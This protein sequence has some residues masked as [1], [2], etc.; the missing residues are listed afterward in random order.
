MC[1]PLHFTEEKPRF[2][3][4]SLLVESPGVRKWWRWQL[5]DPA[6]TDHRLC[7]MVHVCVAMVRGQLKTGNSK[8]GLR[9]HSKCSWAL[10]LSLA[11]LRFP[12][13]LTSQFSFA[14]ASSGFQE[15]SLAR[16]HCLPVQTSCAAGPAEV[17]LHL[18]TRARLEVD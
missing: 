11:L 3:K 8:I 10:Q 1:H 12:A 15:I 2:R 5:R 9:T 16:V 13:A 17:C 14:L 4:R 18:T 7:E 6:R